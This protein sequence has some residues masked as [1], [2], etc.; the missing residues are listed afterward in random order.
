MPEIK[1]TIGEVIQNFV[2]PAFEGLC[3]AVTFAMDALNFLMPVIIGAGAA[4][5]TFNIITKGALIIE[6]LSKAWRVGAAAL[7][8]YR[9]GASLAT[10]AQLALNGAMIIN[11]ITLIAL[12]I[13]A[14]VAA[15]VA[16][17]VVI[18]RNWDQISNFL[19]DVWEGIKNGVVAAWNFISDITKS[20]WGGITTFFTRTIPEKFNEFVQ[21][22]AGLPEKIGT[23]LYDLF[24]V[25]IPYW[26]GY[27][28][29]Y[30]ISYLTENIPKVIQFFKDLPGDIWRWLREV[31][32]RIVTWGAETIR[33][34]AE[35]GNN[36]VN[37]IINYFKEL[38]GKAWEWLTELIKKIV[39]FV[40]K[41]LRAAGDFGKSIF[42]GIID[43][44]KSIPGKIVDLLGD[45]VSYIKKT[46]SNIASAI[47]S[48]FTNAQSGMETGKTSFVSSASS[49]K[50]NAY[51]EGTESA[52]PGLA[53]VGEHG[54]ELIEFHGG[55]RVTPNNRLGGIT[56]NVYAD[57]PS[58]MRQANKYGEAIV[59]KL[60][61]LG[62]NPA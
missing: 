59:N 34:V 38:P 23:F 55:E 57:N 44:I 7:E 3:K 24:F 14:A 60:R 4:F 52:V 29:G 61:T 2:K 11:P 53:L 41:A 42:D 46:A 20:I 5:L 25:K 45:V 40:P 30:M 33:K 16:L 32:N 18:I 6:T 31:I 58:D 56:L 36:I 39:D 49:Y 27:G 37:S 48:I 19:V 54:P 12:A 26:I 21:F 62:V 8:L 15:I 28:M 1:K 35:I 9:A 47:G 13:A 51:A 43:F 22:F 50:T 10:I 17:T